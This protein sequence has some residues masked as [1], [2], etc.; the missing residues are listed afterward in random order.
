[1]VRQ[2]WKEEEMLL[3]MNQLPGVDNPRNYPE[4]IVKELEELLLSG[5]A[6][7]PDPKRKGFYDLENERRTFFVQISPT[8]GRAVLLATW[9][10]T[11]REVVFAGCIDQAVPCTA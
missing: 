4:A 9:L 11:E 6:A 5:V 8:T 1:M 2:S 10:G 7:S 3:R